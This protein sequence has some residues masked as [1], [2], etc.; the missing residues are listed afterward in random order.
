MIVTTTVVIKHDETKL[1]KH[2][3][4]LVKEKKYFK[5]ESDNF[6]KCF[7]SRPKFVNEKEFLDGR[8]SEMD[9]SYNFL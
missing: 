7:R 4:K 6:A 5:I 9:D 8:N 3:E 2:F 1:M